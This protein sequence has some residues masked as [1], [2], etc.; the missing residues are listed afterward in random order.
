MKKVHIDVFIEDKIL[1]L[2]FFRLMSEN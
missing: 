2:Y 1:C